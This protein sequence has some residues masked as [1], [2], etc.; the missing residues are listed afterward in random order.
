M[1]EEI[2]VPFLIIVAMILICQSIFLFIHA[3]KYSHNYW[4]WGIV[5]LI[6]APMPTLVYLIFVRKVFHKKNSKGMKE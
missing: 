5:G 1:N 6:Q 2:P 4:F 3:R